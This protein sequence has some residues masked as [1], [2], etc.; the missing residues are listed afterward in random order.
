METGD[1]FPLFYDLQTIWIIYRGFKEIEKL[2]SLYYYILINASHF[3]IISL[4]S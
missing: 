2:L 1:L 4:P 3:K